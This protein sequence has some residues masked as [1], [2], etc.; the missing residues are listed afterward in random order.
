[1]PEEDVI[2]EEKGTV[3][4]IEDPVPTCPYCGTRPMRIVGR[5]FEMGPTVLMTLLCADC[6]K[7]ITIFPFAIN[8]EKARREESRL[9]LPN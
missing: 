4:V 7:V 2:Q 1:M 9:V 3:S 5:P 8:Q 6:E